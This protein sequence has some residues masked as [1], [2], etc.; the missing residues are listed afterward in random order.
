MVS[1]IT[2]MEFAN[3]SLLDEASAAGESV[4]MAWR[5]MKKKK[6]TIII[7]NKLFEASK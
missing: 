6:N 7:S 2:G 4:L 5:Q 3:A 1:R